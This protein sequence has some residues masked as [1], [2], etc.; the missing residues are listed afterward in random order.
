[1]CPL[2]ATSGHHWTQVNIR[3]ETVEGGCN[4]SLK[5]AAFASASIAKTSRIAKATGLDGNNTIFGTLGS[6]LL[7]QKMLKSAAFCTDQTSSGGDTPRHVELIW[8]SIYYA[9]VDAR[10]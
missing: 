6:S 1:M 10:S 4:R 9:P 2:W 3:R 7:Q 5:C 8:S